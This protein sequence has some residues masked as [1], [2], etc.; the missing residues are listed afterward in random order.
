LSTVRCQQKKTKY[1]EEYL[2]FGN[3]LNCY[4]FVL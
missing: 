4:L 2:V 1:P 3:L